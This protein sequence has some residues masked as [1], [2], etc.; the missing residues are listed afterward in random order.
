VISA[1][2]AQQF[3]AVACFGDDFKIRHLLEHGPQ[4]LAKH[5]VVV[6]EGDPHCHGLKISGCVGRFQEPAT[7]VPAPPIGRSIL[8]HRP[9]DRQKL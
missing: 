2:Q 3:P 4:G 1:D 5:L 6:G 9:K 8:P 7:V